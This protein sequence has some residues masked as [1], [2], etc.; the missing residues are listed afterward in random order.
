MGSTLTT[1]DFALKRRYTDRQIEDLT[2]SDKPF[3]AKVNKNT[4][5]S[6][7]STVVPLQVGNAQGIAGQSRA[8]AQTNQT[9]VRGLAF[10]LVA[11][12]YFG[13]TY[14]GDK[15]IEASRNNPGAFFDDKTAET[16]ALWEQMSQNL[17]LYLFGNGGQAIGRRLSAS[18]NDITLTN[19]A[20]IANFE[21]GMAVVAAAND[22]SDA[23]N[24]PR[25]GS[26]TVTAVNRVTGVVTLASA[27]GITAFADNDYLFRQGDFFGNTGTVVLKGIGAY[28]WGTDTPPALYGMT[29]TS[30]VVRLAGCRLQSAVLAGKGTEERIQLLG[31][32]MAGVYRQQPVDSVYLHPID[33]QYLSQALQSSGY[34]AVTDE[35]TRFGFQVIKW[36][37]GGKVVEIY[38]D[39][40][41]PQGTAFALNMKSW[42]LHSMNKLI[43]PLERDGL[44]MLRAATNDEYEYRLISYPVLECNAPG[45]NG[46]VPV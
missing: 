24:A 35:S 34:R 21:I 25:V 26:T 20:D 8:L 17:A 4:E 42:R 37:V 46:R 11:G 14:I 32:Y 3:L 15:V 38:A 1:F 40:F 43:H 2:I 19:Q 27:A 30:D 36:A 16:D 12:D 29:R 9:N 5:F 10:N 23:A 28:I 33:W 44:T 18:T 45:R 13:S 39:P 7:S 6:G 31:A 41:C 22:G